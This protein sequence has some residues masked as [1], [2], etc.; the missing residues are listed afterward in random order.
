[1][2]DGFLMPDAPTGQSSS[3][4][5]TFSVV[6]AA[7]RASATVAEA[8][9]SALSQEPPPV[10]VIVAYRNADDD[11]LEGALERFAD[12][13]VLLRD[14]DSGAPA[15]LNAAIDRAHGDFVV[16]LDADDVFL[17]GYLE[18]LGE[19][20]RRRP[21][22]DLLASDLWIERAGVTPV[23]FFSQETPFPLREQRQAML[24]RCFVLWPAMRRDLVLRVGGLDPAVSHA[25]DWDLFLRL[26]LAGG[27][28]G[29]VDE[30]L[31]VYRQRDDSMAADRS[32]ML[33]GRLTVLERAARDDT[34]SSEERRHLENLIT[35][36]RRDALLSEAEVAL[37]DGASDA[38]RRSV[39]V[40]RAPG[41]VLSARLKALLAALMP[42]LAAR[43]LRQQGPTLR[44][45]RRLPPSTDGGE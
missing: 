24:E 30:P 4:R 31:W 33:R 27:R 25:Y 11:N 35:A 39:E 43:R 38:R 17:P 10:E 7:Y 16:N 23:R 41:M 8:L 19:L 29:L 18:R 37:L 6:M 1:M 5:P 42:G 26:V 28:V 12:R 3:S 15:A 22:L 21:D 2:E 36:K 44:T 20:G 13:V 14:D 45:H 9:E 40:A 32:A 34:L